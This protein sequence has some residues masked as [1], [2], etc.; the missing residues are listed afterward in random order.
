MKRHTRCM[1]FMDIIIKV[2][3]DEYCSY[4]CI[5]KQLD[6]QFG[7]SSLL[8]SDFTYVTNALILAM[9]TQPESQWNAFLD[10]RS[11]LI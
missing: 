4:L 5:I 1:Q 6:M 8:S 11:R 3:F 2:S 7:K 9:A 10:P